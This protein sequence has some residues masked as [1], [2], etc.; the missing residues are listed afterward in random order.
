MLTPWSLTLAFLLASPILPF[1]W[2]HDIAIAICIFLLIKWLSDYRKC[3]VSY[4]ECKLRGVSKESGYIYMYLD[5][6]LNLN[7]HPDYK[8]FYLFVTVVLALNLWSKRVSWV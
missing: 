7:R 8:L 2:S 4:L 5:P 1:K 3:T 6:V